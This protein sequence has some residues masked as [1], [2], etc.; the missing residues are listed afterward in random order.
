VR[1]H[2]GCVLVDDADAAL[3]DLAEALRGKS[4]VVVIDGLDRL[5][6]GRRDQATAMLR[7]AAAS[8]PL[9]VFATASDADAARTTLAEAGWPDTQT[10]DT[11][12]PR[13]S[14]AE[15]TEVTA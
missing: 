11:R 9:A 15:S 2:V 14:A 10:L 13:R 4:T 8:R 1:S 3:G 12:A 7:D 5:T 6:G